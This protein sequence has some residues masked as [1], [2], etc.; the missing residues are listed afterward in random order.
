MDEKVSAIICFHDFFYDGFYVH[1]MDHGDPKTIFRYIEKSLEEVTK[2]DCTAGSLMPA[3]ISTIYDYITPNVSMCKSLDDYETMYTY[4]FHVG[5][6]K[7]LLV[8]MWKCK[9]CLLEKVTLDEA[10]VFVNDG[11]Y[12]PTVVEGELEWEPRLFELTNREPDFRID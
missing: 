6:D 1:L 7:A 9:D 12:A 2:S 3:F 11:F 10:K 4:S 5:K 8:L